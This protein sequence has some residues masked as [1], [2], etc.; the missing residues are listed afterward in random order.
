MNVLTDTLLRVR[1]DVG[2]LLMVVAVMASGVAVIYSKHMAR[3]EFI[4]MQQLENKRD[5]LN[6]EWGRLLLEQST[7]TTPAR[8]EQQARERLQM[9]TPANRNTVVITP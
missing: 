7:W 6:E 3:S 8:V 9:I 2:L 1:I 4:A 5:L